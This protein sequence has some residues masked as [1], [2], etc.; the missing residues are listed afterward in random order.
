MEEKK[1]GLKIHT[2]LPL[3]G[4][5]PDLIIMSEAA[6]NDKD[7]LGQLEVEPGKIYLFDKKGMLITS[8]G[9]NGLRGGILPY[10]T[11]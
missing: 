7:F 11:Q 9:K 6:K 4:F 8:S 10:M 5:V 2:K 1:G 3:T